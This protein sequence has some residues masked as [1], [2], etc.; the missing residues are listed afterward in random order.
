MIRW[1]QLLSF[2]GFRRDPGSRHI[3]LNESLHAALMNLAD[4]EQRPAEQIQ[5]DLLAAGLA[6][7]H[8]R[9]ELWQC[10]ESLTPRERDEAAWT[11]KEQGRL[12]IGEKTTGGRPGTCYRAV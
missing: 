12:T 5:A 4:R 3:E 7:H 6:Q 9:D 8:I 2:L 11:L 1:Q 10:W